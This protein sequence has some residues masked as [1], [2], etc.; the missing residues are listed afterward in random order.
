MNENDTYQHPDITK[1]LLS[2]GRYFDELD[3]L[4]WEKTFS[5]PN[6]RRGDKNVKELFSF[7]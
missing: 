1:A 4:E 3:E 6:K 5:N 7:F 2:G